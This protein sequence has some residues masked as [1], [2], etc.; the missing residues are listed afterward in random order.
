M[1]ILPPMLD[2]LLGVSEKLFLENVVVEPQKDVVLRV[3]SA[4]EA[5]SEC[6][7]YL[8]TRR[9][10]GAVLVLDSEASVQDTLYLMLRPWIPDLVPENPGEKVANTYSI[11]DFTSRSG[12]FVIEAKFIRTKEHGKS[13]VSELNN[14][15]ESYRYHSHC[16]DLIF[17]IYDPESLIPDGS[18]LR[19]HLISSRTYGDKTLRCHAVIKP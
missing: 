1:M 12:R 18:A 7:R 5:F 14:D 8:N 6:V 2:G 15:I 10:Q 16:D 3:V 13:V 11:K 4:L 9:S 19:A 17:F